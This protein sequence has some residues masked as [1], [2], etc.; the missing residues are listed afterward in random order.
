MIPHLKPTLEVQDKAALFEVLQTGMVARGTKVAEFECAVADYMGLGGA[1][2]TS[3]GA[4]SLVL[5]LKS[6]GIKRGDEVIIPTY[7]CHEV[8]D[9]V[10]FTG[11]TT[12]LCDVGDDD[13]NM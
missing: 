8:L 1:V 7:V 10:T 13:W 3:S 5:T 12:V 2:A 11:A 4:A 9:A 6:L